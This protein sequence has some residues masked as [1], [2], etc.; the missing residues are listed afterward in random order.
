MPAPR[1]AVAV[2]LGALAQRDVVVAQLRPARRSSGTAGGSWSKLSSAVVASVPIRSS[3]LYDATCD[4]EHVL[5]GVLVA[6]VAGEALLVAV[7]HD[8]RAAG[9]EV[10]DLG[11]LG[12]RPATA[13]AGVPARLDRPADAADVVVADELGEPEGVGVGVGEPVVVGEQ[14]AQ[15]VGR[16]RRGDDA[17]DRAVEA[18]V[19]RRRE[20]QLGRE[21]RQ[22]G[23]VAV[24]DL[25]EEGEV[26]CRAAACLD[27]RH[28]LLPQLVVDVLDGVDAE[29]VDVERARSS[30]VWMSIIPSTTSG[31][32]VNRSSRPTKSPYSEFSPANVESPRLWY[33][34]RSLSQS[35]DLTVASSRGRGT[36][37]CTGS[38]PPGRAR[39]T[40]RYR[41]SRG[42]RTARRTRRGT[43]TSVLLR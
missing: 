27:G 8:G 43:G 23:R 1:L 32:S 4:G 10:E 24:E 41:R 33:S 15:A 42:R 17:A 40:C 39:G 18:E 14:R 19:E 12:A 2:Q 16:R 13:S 7:V 38:S 37:G 28:E 22:E 11:E 25:T 29:A 21:A 20:R 3:S 31:C 34:V 36:S 5:A 9:R 26:V 6:A 30:P 35:G